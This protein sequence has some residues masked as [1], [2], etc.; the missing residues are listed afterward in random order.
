M[1]A[2]RLAKAATRGLV[3]GRLKESFDV[4]ALVA[5]VDIDHYMDG[6]DITYASHVTDV[7]IVACWFMMREIE[8]AVGR[9]VPEQHGLLTSTRSRRGGRPSLLAGGCSALVARVA[10]YL[11]LP[12]SE[13]SGPG[14]AK[15]VVAS[16]FGAMKAAG[17][18]IHVMDAEGRQGL[19][20]WSRCQGLR[21]SSQPVNG[22]LARCW[23][24]PSG[25]RWPAGP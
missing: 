16:H 6:F 9:R 22:T 20:W 1:A 3:A 21:R 19:I 12:S 4:D 10:R 5:V 7:L 25:S 14:G 2:R 23:P 8:M 15:H 11:T 17:I 13:P 18:P 24:D